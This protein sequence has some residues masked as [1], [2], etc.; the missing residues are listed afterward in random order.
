MPS[1]SLPL[2]SHTCHCGKLAAKVASMSV[3]HSKIPA[4]S[5]RTKY[6]AKLRAGSFRVWLG[7]AELSLLRTLAPYQ[8]VALPF[9]N[10]ASA[11]LDHSCL[12]IRS[13]DTHPTLSHLARP[14]HATGRLRARRLPGPSCDVYELRQV[15]P[16][17]DD[18]AVRSGPTRV[19]FSAIIFVAVARLS[20]GKDLRTNSMS[21]SVNSGAFAIVISPVHWRQGFCSRRFLL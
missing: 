10:L 15:A 5:I 14:A 1:S 9:G 18:F 8:V 19:V 13:T 11:E 17:I 12:T 21:S 6:A 3:S 2:I 4:M 7:P 16:T 20:L